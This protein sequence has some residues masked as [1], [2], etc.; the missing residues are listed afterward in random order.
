MYDLHREQ[1]RRHIAS[2]QPKSKPRFAAGRSVLSIA[3]GAGDPDV[4]AA[5]LEAGAAVLYSRDGYDVL[6]DAVHSHDII[7]DARLANL[8]R[9]LI[10]AG[11]PLNTVTGYLNTQALEWRKVE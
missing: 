10:T 5:L 1:K 7:R 6:I 2:A 11:A 4:A 8:L 9:L 3:V